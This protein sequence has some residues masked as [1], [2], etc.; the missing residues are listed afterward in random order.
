MTLLQV[1]LFVLVAK[2][3]NFSQASD[4][5][6]ISQSSTS[7]YISSLESELG[8]Q[9][10][11]RTNKSV[12]LTRFGEEFYPYAMALVGA[13]SDVNDFV[14]SQR[15][16]RT[17]WIIGLTDDL[18]DGTNFGFFRAYINALHKFH[19]RYKDIHII[20]RFYPSQELFALLSA[21][22]AD[23]AI[24]PVCDFKFE[25]S[26]P[27][28]GQF[29]RL[30]HTPNYLILPRNISPTAKMEEIGRKLRTLYYL[31]NNVN[32]HLILQL[33][34]VL[35]SSPKLC[36]CS[37]PMELLLR[38]SAYEE[39]AA[40]VAE[41][42]LLSAFHD[43]NMPVISLDEASLGSGLYLVWERGKEPEQVQ[44]L[45]ELITKYITIETKLSRY[46]NLPFYD[47]RL[48]DMFFSKGSEEP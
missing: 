13:E 26:F 43:I 4:S 7:K 38:M 28:S 10:F 21:G 42:H 19:E 18:K 17:H 39:G 24:V 11:N 27:S 31:P 23:C 48:S 45:C 16:S 47:E 12:T 29:F 22:K 1:K 33:N 15:R 40:A 20:T 8:F 41:Q 46:A 36:P 5:L 35:R 2:Y 14:N 25:D 32:Q 44:E 3:G 6:Y 37:A 9:L 34:K 30:T